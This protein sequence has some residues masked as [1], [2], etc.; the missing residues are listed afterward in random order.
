M[1]DSQS[2]CGQVRIKSV[3]M[4]SSS[5]RIVGSRRLSAAARAA[6]S[7]TLR[8]TSLRASVGGLR[9]G[10]RSNVGGIR[11]Y[12]TEK[13]LELRNGKKGQRILYDPTHETE[14]CGVGLIASLK[15]TPS[16]TIIQHAD[17]M[18]IRMAHRGGCGCD[19]ASGDGSGT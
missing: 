16:R 6:T 3:R 4:I 11:V 2:L 5:A 10:L 14:N 15:S 8:R 19:P 9:H 17:E 1:I 12:S 7:R 13:I 18:L